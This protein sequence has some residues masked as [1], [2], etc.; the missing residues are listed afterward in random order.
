MESNMGPHLGTHVFLSFFSKK[1]P[2]LQISE[3]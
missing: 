2:N 3:L 1:F